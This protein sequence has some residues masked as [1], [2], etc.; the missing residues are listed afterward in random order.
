[1]LIKA[2]DDK[3]PQIDALD[4][5]RRVPTSTRHA[6]DGSSRRSGPSGRA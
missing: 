6:V 3:Q 2:A 4:A 5:A 1:M